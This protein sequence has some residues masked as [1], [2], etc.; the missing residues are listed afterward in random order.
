[1]YVYSLHRVQVHI[2]RT[3]YKHAKTFDNASCAKTDHLY[4]WA[5]G[6][7]A[8]YLSISL[9]EKEEQYTLRRP[10]CSKALAVHSY[11]CN[12]S[13]DRKEVLDIF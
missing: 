2:Q 5:V 11:L 12:F 7:L 6:A 4:E 9:Y 10:R 3:Q 8:I 1:M 13:K